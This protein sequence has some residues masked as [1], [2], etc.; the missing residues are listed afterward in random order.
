MILGSASMRE[1]ETTYILVGFS[2]LFRPKGRVS[3]TARALVARIVAHT[4]TG[5][6]SCRSLQSF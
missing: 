5:E 4:N 1:I 6:G 2:P 3:R